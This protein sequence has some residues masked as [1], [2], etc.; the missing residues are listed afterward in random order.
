MTALFWKRNP[1]PF[2]CLCPSDNDVEKVVC[3]R[4]SSLT[5][6][7]NSK[8][9]KFLNEILIFYRRRGLPSFDETFTGYGMNKVTHTNLLFASG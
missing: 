2:G 7:I 3:C 6:P 1:F 4:A 8:P 9:S 5:K